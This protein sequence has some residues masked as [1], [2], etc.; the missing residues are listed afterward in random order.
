MTLKLEFKEL[1]IKIHGLDAKTKQQIC[2]TL[3]KMTIPSSNKGKAGV[4][5]ILMR[6]FVY[7]YPSLME[8]NNQN[9]VADFIKKTGL[10]DVQVLKSVKA[11]IDKNIQESHSEK[12]QPKGRK[13]R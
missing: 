11:L 6:L 12:P 9:Q 10:N 2:A 1:V 8:N 4:Y 3:D 7:Y 13:S 5:S